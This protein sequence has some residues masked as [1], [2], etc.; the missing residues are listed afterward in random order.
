ML[1]IRFENIEKNFCPELAVGPHDV[2]PKALRERFEEIFKELLETPGKWYITVE[3]SFEFNKRAVSFL[4]VMY[5]SI[6]D[7]V[8]RKLDYSEKIGII[9]SIADKEGYLQQILER[10]KK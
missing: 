1:K 3:S 5:H 6:S 4:N 10:N 7:M 2:T 9:C 8:E